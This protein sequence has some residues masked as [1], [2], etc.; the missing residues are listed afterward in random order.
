MEN[1]DNAKW[2]IDEITAHWWMGNKVEFLVKWNSDSIWEP[3]VHCKDLEVLNE[4][5]ELHRA[6][7][8]QRLPLGSQHTHNV[9]CAW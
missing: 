7:L 3:H 2:L 4:Y 8:V 5:L 9:L 1:P 6:Q